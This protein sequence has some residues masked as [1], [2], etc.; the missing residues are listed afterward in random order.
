MGFSDPVSLV[1]CN[2]AHADPHILAMIGIDQGLLRP[3]AECIP[4]QLLESSADRVCRVRKIRIGFRHALGSGT[5]QFPLVGIILQQEGDIRSIEGEQRRRSIRDDINTFRSI[6]QLG[7]FRGLNLET[8]ALHEGKRIIIPH[9]FSIVVA[10][11][12]AASDFLQERDLLLG[13]YSFCQGL[14]A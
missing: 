14:D 12:P 11:D 13:F 10:L 8:L 5:P 7:F 4:H 6:H 9:R 1:S 2:P 3:G